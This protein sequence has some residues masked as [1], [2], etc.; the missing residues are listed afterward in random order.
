MV[1]LAPPIGVTRPLRPGSMLLDISYI[2]LHR[3]GYGG[4]QHGGL[5]R[6]QGE[7]GSNHV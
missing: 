4:A 6:V 1:L 3:D 7:R 2:R 5:S